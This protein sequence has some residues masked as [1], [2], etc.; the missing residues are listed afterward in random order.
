[1]NRKSEFKRREEAVWK[2]FNKWSQT[3]KECLLQEKKKKKKE[4]WGYSLS[5]RIIQDLISLTHKSKKPILL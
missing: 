5:Y 1:M 2:V 4:N 3:T